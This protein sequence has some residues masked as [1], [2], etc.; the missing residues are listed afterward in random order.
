MDDDNYLRQFFFCSNKETSVL[1]YMYGWNETDH[2]GI[3]ENERI[4]LQVTFFEHQIKYGHYGSIRIFDECASFCDFFFGG[5]GQSAKKKISPKRKMK[6]VRAHF[7]SQIYNLI[8]IFFYLCGTWTLSVRSITSMIK[9]MIYNNKRRL[10][11]GAE[12]VSKMNL[13]SPS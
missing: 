5:K 3:S 13:C 10:G 2:C 7:F 8:Y 1:I 12:T 4:K 6:L 9:I 11:H